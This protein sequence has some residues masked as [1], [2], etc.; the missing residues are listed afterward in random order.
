MF[1]LAHCPLSFQVVT[2]VE[3]KS[4]EARQVNTVFVKFKIIQALSFGLDLY[5]SQYNYHKYMNFRIFG[6]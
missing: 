4:K 6:L 3:Y 5:L 2:L 1:I